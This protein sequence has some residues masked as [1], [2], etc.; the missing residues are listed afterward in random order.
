VRD[1]ENLKLVGSITNHRSPTATILS[2]G[3]SPMEEIEYLVPTTWC[4]VRVCVCGGG[5]G[6]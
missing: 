5:G 3:G 2:G 4:S 1:K 6:S